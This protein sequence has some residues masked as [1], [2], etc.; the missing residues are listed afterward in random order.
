MIRGLQFSSFIFQVSK[1]ALIRIIYLHCFPSQYYGL[2]LDILILGLQR[3]S[4]MAGPPQMPNNFLQFR[5]TA[6]EIR[7]PIRLYSRY[8]DRIH[9][10]LRF[11]ADESRDLI[12]RYLSA[13]PDPNNEKYA[14][15]PRQFIRLC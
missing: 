11:T 14:P 13:N 8:V 15:H 2:V 5:D 1:S 10:M 4:E 7:H 9:I 3:A 6:T 12:Q